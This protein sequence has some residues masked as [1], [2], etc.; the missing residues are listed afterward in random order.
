MYG[1]W[2]PEKQTQSGFQKETESSSNY[3]DL[4]GRNAYRIVGTFSGNQRGLEKHLDASNEGGK[5]ACCYQPETQG[6]QIQIKMQCVLLPL[7]FRKAM[8]VFLG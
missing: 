5:G 7:A 6:H 1:H 4:Y 3:T 2:V 8:T